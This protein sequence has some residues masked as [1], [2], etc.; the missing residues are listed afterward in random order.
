MFGMET[1][2]GI[3][4]R[5]QGIDHRFVVLR[6]PMMLVSKVFSALI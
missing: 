6:I 4:V 1:E 3:D 5:E 2:F